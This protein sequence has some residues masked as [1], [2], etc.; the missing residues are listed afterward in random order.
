[1]EKVW[2]PPENVL[3]CMGALELFFHDQ[4]EHTSVL[5]KA[6][7]AH[8]QF[9]TIHPFFDGN[10]AFIDNGRNRAR[11]ASSS[12]LSAGGGSGCKKTFPRFDQYH[13]N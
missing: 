9:E 7:L 12:D 8:V 5:L 1:L 10:R 2:P 13:S 3:E 6:A 4:P 11:K